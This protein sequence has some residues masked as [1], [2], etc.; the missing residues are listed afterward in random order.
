[1]PLQRRILFPRIS[2]RLL[3]D[4]NNHQQQEAVGTLDKN[5]K[6]TVG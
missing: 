1:V 6:R 3:D 2:L 4:S 5:K